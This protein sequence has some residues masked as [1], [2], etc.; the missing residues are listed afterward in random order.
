MKTRKQIRYLRRKAV[1]NSDNTKSIFLKIILKDKMNENKLISLLEG[2]RQ[3]SHG[4]T[5]QYLKYKN[6]IEEIVEK[7]L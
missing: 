1:K 2:I 4:K 7:E 5:K 3:A 6:Y